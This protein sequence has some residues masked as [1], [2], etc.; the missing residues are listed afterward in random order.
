MGRL[1]DH[2]IDVLRSLDRRAGASRR[3]ATVCL[4]TDAAPLHRNGASR[5]GVMTLGEH[6]FLIYH[7]D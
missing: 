3:A 1:V 5:D 2:Q 4:Q 7:Y 6:N